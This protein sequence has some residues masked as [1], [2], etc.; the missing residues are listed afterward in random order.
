MNM[1]INP[2]LTLLRRKIDIVDRQFLR[3]L[4][5]RHLI[6]RAIATEKR[7]NRI[8]ITDRQREKSMI[9]DWLTRASALGLRKRFIRLLIHVIIAES[10]RMQEEI[11]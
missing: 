8:A 3:L 11:V 6:S 10:K 9:T 2:S 7:K 4:S 5:K 1:R